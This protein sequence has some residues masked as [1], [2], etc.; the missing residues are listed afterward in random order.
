MRWRALILLRTFVTESREY[1]PRNENLFSGSHSSLTN[2]WWSS[3]QSL[4]FP[5]LFWLVAPTIFQVT[6]QMVTACKN[7]LTDRGVNRVW[8]QPRQPLIEKL[9]ACLRLNQEYQKCFQRTKRRIAEDPTMKP[10]EF[11]EMYIFG[12]FDTFCKRLNQVRITYLKS[13]AKYFSHNYRLPSLLTYCPNL[14]TVSR[15][16][17]K[18]FAPGQP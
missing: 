5:Q 16:S 17:R 1:L 13:F 6:N 7:Y 9:K 15:R 11:S 12:K 3:L 10:F 14:G 2:P 8:D 18:C 4:E